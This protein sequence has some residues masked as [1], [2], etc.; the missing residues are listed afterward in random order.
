MANTP[1]F[2]SGAK[3]YGRDGR[4][5]TV[6]AAEGGTIYCIATNGT[7]TEFPASELCNEREWAAR[8]NGRRDISY[9]RLRQSR[10]Y[11]T[12]GAKVDRAGA[13]ALLAKVE[14][15]KPGLLD[16]VAHDIA[17]RT[18][19]E[20]KDHDLV[21][22]LSIVKARE[23]FDEARPEV[24]ATLVANLLGAEPEKIVAAT[25]LGDN[26]MRAMV[27]RGMGP[28]TDIFEEFCDRPRK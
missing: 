15:L 10:A 18:L 5:Y 9:L 7:E 4:V 22:K 21:A 28:L 14:R 2:P 16:F 19:A 23:M 13:E 27:D 25:Q 6:E 8:A 3:A 12:A 17:A 26:L 11:L 20:H 1:R 24:R